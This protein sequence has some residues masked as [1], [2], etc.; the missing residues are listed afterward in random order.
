MFMARI[1]FAAAPTVMLVVVAGVRC[2]CR[3]APPRRDLWA[4]VSVAL[5]AF[6]FVGRLVVL[7]G[8][9]GGVRVTMIFM[10]LSR[11]LSCS[12]VRAWA[13]CIGG[14]SAL[15]LTMWSPVSSP[16]LSAGD[17]VSTPCT[18]IGMLWSRV[19]LAPKYNFPCCRF[20]STTMLSCA[21]V[22]VRCRCVAGVWLFDCDGCRGR[23]LYSGVLVAAA[24]RRTLLFPRVNMLCTSARA[25]RCTIAL[26][27]VIC[28]IAIWVVPALLLLWLLVVLPA[29]PPRVSG[30]GV[31]GVV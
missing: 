12:H 19:I 4:G 11:N 9:C 2:R 8:F 27:I 31:A 28:P 24:C 10:R 30:G 16:A 20:W 13:S 29:D 1:L 17:L 18:V 6:G 22:V 15:M 25:S 23:F 21:L 5:P 14:V 3:P 26:V 7:A